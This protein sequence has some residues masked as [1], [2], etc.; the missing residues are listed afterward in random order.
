MANL[1]EVEDRLQDIF[2]VPELPF[3]QVVLQVDS[4]LRY[5]YVMQLLDTCVRI[6]LHTGE[7]LRRLSFVE[8]PEGETSEVPTNDSA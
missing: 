7:P 2:S 4:R 8:L 6:K 1:K 5:Q 3:E